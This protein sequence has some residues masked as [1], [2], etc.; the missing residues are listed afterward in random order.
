MYQLFEPSQSLRHVVKY[1]WLLDLNGAKGSMKDHLFAYPYVNWVFTIGNP[2]VI[3]NKL[4]GSTTVK[5]TRIIGPR[6]TISEYVHPAGSLTFGITFHTGSTVSLFN[7]STNLITDKIITYDQL[8]PG[9]HWLNSLFMKTSIENFLAELNLQLDALVNTNEIKGYFLYK[10]FSSLLK[11]G[12]HYNTST[13]NLASKINISQRQLQRITLKYAGLSPK[14]VQSMIRC[15]LAL[16]SIQQSGQSSDLFQYGYYD[17][18]H[19]IKDVKKWTG[20]TPGQILKVVSN[21]SL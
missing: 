8:L 19:F 11:D 15:K 7:K 20:K 12:T 5:D 14:Q 3:K 6:T 21:I 1:Y 9:M 17:Q 2:Y 4:L 16:C 10:Q 18:N 13:K